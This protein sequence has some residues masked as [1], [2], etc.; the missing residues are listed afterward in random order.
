MNTDRI[1]KIIGYSFG[2]VNT[3]TEALTHSSRG[4]AYSYERLEF[5]GDAVLE[6][7]V[8]E[9][10]F[11]EHPEYSEGQMTSLRSKLVRED[12][13]SKWA[14]E[15]D[16][17]S[18]LILGKGEENNNGRNKKSIL[19]DMVESLIGAIYLDGGF[20][21]A[22]KFC[23]E[24]LFNGNDIKLETDHKS[25]LQEYVQKDGKEHHIVYSLIKDEGPAHAKIFYSNVS[26]DGRELGEGKGTSKQE[27]EK[28]AAA[29][30]LI[31][32]RAKENE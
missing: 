16:L 26:V 21:E 1:E 8:S 28:S 19:C 2:N 31:V 15:N 6:L 13:L 14:L 27:S 23:D 22:K 24:K 4:L 18:F 29:A 11:I 30:A 25:L 12:Y 3:L 17:G 10:I 32:L 9:H 7:I 20:D 5:L